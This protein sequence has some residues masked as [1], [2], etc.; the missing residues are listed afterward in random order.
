MRTNPRV[1][2]VEDD[3]DRGEALQGWLEAEG[4]DVTTC[5][6]PEA[7]SFVC[8]GDRTGSCPLIEDADVVV[9]N[10]GLRC[11]EVVEGTSPFDLLALYRSSELPVVALNGLEAAELLRD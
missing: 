4:F 9:L 7:P 3:P 1:L 11:G 10:C 2:V 6:G 5:P 8:G